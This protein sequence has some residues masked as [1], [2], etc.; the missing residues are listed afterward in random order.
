MGGS[1]EGDTYFYVLHPTQ[2][3]IQLICSIPVVRM[4]FQ[5]ENCVDPDKI[6]SSEAKA[7]LN[8]LCFQKRKNMGSEG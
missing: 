8:L 7:D 2:I 3:L 4:H 6:A 1:S 5:S